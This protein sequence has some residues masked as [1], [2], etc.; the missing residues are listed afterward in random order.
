MVI[1]MGRFIAL[2]LIMGGEEEKRT[3]WVFCWRGGIPSME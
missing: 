1:T 2:D 3:S